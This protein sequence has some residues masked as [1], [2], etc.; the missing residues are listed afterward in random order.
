MID[1]RARDRDA[2]ERERSHRHRQ[3]ERLAEHLR[4]LRPRVACEVGNVEATASP[5]SRPTPVSAPG[6]MCQK[7]SCCGL[8]RG[9]VGEH[10]AETAAR[11]MT[12]IPRR[13]RPPSRSSGAA[14]RLE[15]LDPLDS[16]Q[17]D[18]DLDQPE[19]EER[20]PRV[21]RD[22]AD[23]RAEIRPTAPHRSEKRV[24]RAFRRSTSVSRTSRRRRSPAVSPECSLLSFRSEARQRT[25]NEI[26]YFVPA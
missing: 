13:T 8:Q 25:G 11:R 16:L 9:R 20:D 18:D 4:P 22:A 15:I 14:Q 12:P 24:E 2:D 3:P 21:K 6:K 17:D 26:P 23:I 10:V 5:S 19:D 7:L 1:R